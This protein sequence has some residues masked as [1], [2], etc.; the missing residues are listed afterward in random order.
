MSDLNYNI[1]EKVTNNGVTTNVSITSAGTHVSYLDPNNNLV[2][3]YYNIP[4]TTV[5]EFTDKTNKYILDDQSASIESL[6]QDIPYPYGDTYFVT[7]VLRSYIDYLLTTNAQSI[8]LNNLDTYKYFNDFYGILNEV[9]IPARYHAIILRMNGFSDTGL[10]DPSITSIIVPDF[11][12]IDSLAV[13]YVN[14]INDPFNI[15]G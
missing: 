15:N 3:Y 8:D 2:Q 7:V 11:T 14:T 12:I 5:R 13:A 4:S 10:Y 1:K 6:S 9:G